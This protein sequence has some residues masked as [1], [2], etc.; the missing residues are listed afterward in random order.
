MSYKFQ[1]NISLVKQRLL[2]AFF[3]L[4]YFNPA[5][6]ATE[7]TDTVKGLD[8]IVA[9]VDQSVI[10]EHELQER[11]RIVSAQL[12]KNGS[13]LPEQ[14]VLE[15]QI[16]ERLIIDR[17]QLDFAAQTGLKVDDAMLDKTIQRIAEQNKLSVPEFQ[18][19][20]EADG[21]SFRKFR[22]DIRNEVIIARLREREVDNRINVTE[23]EIDN[24][25]TTQSSSQD[26]Q[27]EFE[28]SHIL[29]RTPE[30]STPEQLQKLRAKAEQALKQLQGGT[31]FAQ[32]SASFSDAPN[33][34]EGGGLGWKTSTQVPALFLDA[35]KT[36]Q[37]GQLSPILRSP[38]GFHILKMT[39]RR[40]GTSPLVIEQTHVRHIL[41]KLSEI[42][43]DSDAKTR[44]DRIKERLDNGGDFAELAKQNSED[45]SAS[46]G[47][48]LGWVNPGDTVPEFEKVMND[49]KPNQIS[50]PVKT[51]FGW[52]I[53]QVLDRRQ[54]DMAK[55]ASRLKAR[56][57]IRARKSDEAYQDWLRELRDR[58]YVELR[59]EDKY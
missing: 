40:G 34:L 28:I 24:F 41:I 9:V 17:L 19:A 52:H 48:D 53:I 37:P 31:D 2:L 14:N 44:M 6:A 33:A 46:N 39:N 45:G 59:L 54:Q 23:A 18:K 22:E 3:A 36:M 13:K 55:D 10:T 43:S 27:D 57:E 56:Q 12:E 35:L 21:I 16:L 51:P 20:L 1:F 8:R 30:D 47:G 11:I 7:S 5:L 49:L 38:N 50:D 4:L 25:L 26:A 58:A 42:V 32:V 15:K 29:V